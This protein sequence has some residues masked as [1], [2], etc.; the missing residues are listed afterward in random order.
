MGTERAVRT[1]NGV[2][3][4]SLIKFGGKI[5]AYCPYSHKWQLV[6]WA[7]LHK[8]FRRSTA[9]QMSKRQLY[10]IWYKS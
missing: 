5:M 4:R 10:A 3:G 9:T 7:V 2:E 8:G 6:D 1:V